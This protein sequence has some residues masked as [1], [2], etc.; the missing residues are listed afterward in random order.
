[1]DDFPANGR[2]WDAAL[3]HREGTLHYILE[4]GPGTSS[5]GT[6]LYLASAPLP[7]GR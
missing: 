4:I 7:D 5:G 1:M 3:I 2:S 6:E